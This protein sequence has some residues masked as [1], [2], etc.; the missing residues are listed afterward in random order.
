MK[1]CLPLLL[2]TMLLTASQITTGQSLYSNINGIGSSYNPKFGASNTPKIVFDDVNIPASK[3]QSSDSLFITKLKLGIVRSANSPAFTANVYYTVFN[4]NPQSNSEL[5]ILPPIFLGSVSFPA[6]PGSLIKDVIS[7]GDSVTTLFK[8]KTLM[9]TWNPGYQTIAIGVS[10][11]INA[12]CG[13]ELSTGPDLSDDG[14]FIYDVDNSSTAIV[15]T[16][17][18]GNP[19]ANFRVELFGKGQ[20]PV[21]VTL[22]K[23]DV[24]NVNKQ[25]SLTWSTSQE[26]NSSYYS[27]ERSNNGTNFTTIGKVAAAGNST[28]ARLYSYTDNNPMAG[29]N[30]Y[31]LKMVDLDNSVKYS[32]IK[33]VKNTSFTSLSIYPNP[34]ANSMKLSI[35]SEKADMG[36][37]TISNIAGQTVYSSQ[38]KVEAGKTLIPINVNTLSSGTYVVKVQLSTEVFTEKF[39]KE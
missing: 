31:R 36:T 37:I 29:I 16:W 10:F 35:T 13:W 4:P 22:T 14:M 8:I 27:I 20:N 15:Y 2:F 12:G 18:G 28:T 38:V 1:K 30:Y 24:Q 17:F 23:F 3:F 6:N 25:N 26:S 11:S 5:L 7:L 39:T 33:S 9:G 19:E 21:P 34:V 32:E